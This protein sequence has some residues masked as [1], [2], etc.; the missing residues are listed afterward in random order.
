MMRLRGCLKRIFYRLLGIPIGEKCLIDRDVTLSRYRGGWI[1]IGEKCEFYKGSVLLTYGGHILI[2]NECSFNQYVV[3]YGH[4][5]L[6]I[7]N[8]VRI[9]NH[10]TIVPANHRFD[11]LSVSIMEQGE[12][13]KGIIIEDDVWIGSG[14]RIL[15]G[16]I[17]R[18]GSVIAAGSVVNR[19]T[20]PYSVWGGIPARFLKQRNGN[21][22]CS[23]S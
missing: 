17:I 4:G 21:S 16:V 19:S 5:G 2:G 15:D 8:K 22:F 14:A 10:V 11:D 13:R 3:I 23:K 20:T 18:K 9:A 7:G 1:K 12:K 6:R